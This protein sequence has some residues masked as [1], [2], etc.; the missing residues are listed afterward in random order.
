[1]RSLVA[2]LS[3]CVFLSSMAHA[4]LT[5]TQSSYPF[6][7]SSGQRADFTGDGFPDLIFSDSTGTTLTVLP[8]LGDGTF[9]S[10]RAFTASQ[11]G[12]IAVL[13]FNRDG[14]TDVAACDGLNLVVLLGNGD[15]TLTAS[16]TVAV[17]CTAVAAGD[18]NHDGNPDTAVTV[19]GS[20]HSGDNQVVVYLGD[21]KGGVSSKVVNHNV[22][23]TGNFGGDC[24]LRGLAQAADFTGDKIT[25][26]AVTARCDDSAFSDGALII[27][28]SDGTGHFSFHREVAVPA[29]INRLQLSD[30]NQDNKQDLIIMS[31]AFLPATLG[32]KLDIL[33]GNGDGT[34]TAQNVPECFWDASNGTD[35]SSVAAADFDGDGTKDLML[36][37]F[38]VLEFL[39]GQSDD[40]FKL[41]QSWPLGFSA[42]LV[43]G[44]FNKD[45]RTDL[46][47]MGPGSTDVWINQTSSA[48]VCRALGNLRT[49]NLCY[50][51]NPTGSFH[52]VATPLDD[53]QIQAMQIYVAGFGFLT[54]RTPDDMINTRILLAGGA[55]RI[56]AKGWDDL[57][58][59]STTIDLVVCTN[60]VFRTVNTCLPQNGSS[61]NNPV[62]IVASASTSLPFSQLQVYIDGIVSFHTSSKYVDNSRK[63]TPGTHRITVK[64][65]DSNGAFSSTVNVTVQ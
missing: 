65:W 41:K 25:D 64:G 4:Q 1:L 11:Q 20:T 2:C 52:F 19:D 63:L 12:S 49:V 28:V 56:T 29:F 16:R 42:F 48:L 27:G 61:L 32:T 62:H 35:C 26:I 55:N 21:G 8:N 36:V 51:G 18:F 45:R 7:S 38:G 47:I 53:R 14:N 33:K 9:D 58:A 40:T 37:K 13:D 44:D 60:N 46:A 43:A 6:P 50:H 39:K 31:A 24:F 23:F 59:F 17:S 22:N 34:F 5:W 54:F 3:M 30:V 15:G 57:G 10:T